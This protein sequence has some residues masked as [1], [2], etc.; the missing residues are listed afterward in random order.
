M[1]R[2][3]PFKKGQ[4]PWNKGIKQWP[5]GLPKEITDKI[6]QRTKGLKQS[7]KHIINRVKIIKQN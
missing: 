1:P 2:G 4:S 7:K 3:K 5:N 6:S